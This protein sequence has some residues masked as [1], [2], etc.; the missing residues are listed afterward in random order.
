M[1]TALYSYGTYRGYDIEHD[2]GSGMWYAIKL[3][4]YGL[5]VHRLT[6]NT[7]DQLVRKISHHLTYGHYLKSYQDGVSIAYSI[8]R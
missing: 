6:A 5:V 1:K 8:P 2:T 7:R 4:R 3:D